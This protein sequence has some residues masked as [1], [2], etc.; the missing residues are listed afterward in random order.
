[1]A[2]NEPEYDRSMNADE[3][4]RAAR[5]TEA[6][7]RIIDECILSNISHHWRKTA[8]LVALTMGDIGANLRLADVFYSGRIKHLAAA[9]LIEADGNLNRMRHSEVRLRNKERG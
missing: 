8:K 9:G 5:L 6:E 1:M 4:A 2:E 7:L 3:Q